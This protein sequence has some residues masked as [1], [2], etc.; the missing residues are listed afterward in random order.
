MQIATSGFHHCVLTK[1]GNVKCWGGG[2]G[3]QLGDG[4]SGLGHVSSTP[5]YVVADANSSSPLANI[6]QIA[7]GGR[8]TCA[9]T[10]A[11]NVKCWGW[12]ESGELGNLTS[13]K[14]HSNV[15]L[16]VNDKDGKPLGSVVQISA[17]MYG[18]YSCALSA[19]GKVMCWGWWL[20]WTAR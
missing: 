18:Y 5:V 4:K 7:N 13:E 17:A 19:T 16:V 9:L 15:P 6:V 20:L 3:G 10:T 2:D 1:A 12:G 14:R 11:G 8:H